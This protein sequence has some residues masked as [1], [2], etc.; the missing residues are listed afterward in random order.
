[1]FNWSAAQPYASWSQV[2]GNRRDQ[3]V[4]VGGVPTSFEWTDQ[5]VALAAKHRLTLLPE[6]VYAPGWD[7]APH[8]AGT[9]GI[10][11]SDAAYAAFLKALVQ[12]Y[13]AHGS[14]WGSHSPAVPIRSWQIWNEPNLSIF[15]P[16][17]PFARSYVALLSAAHAAIKSADPGARIVL[18]GMPNFSWTALRQVY[19]VRGA[20]RLF[21]E[22]AVHPYTRRPEGVIT[23]LR[24]VRQVMN[25]AGDRRKPLIADEISWPSSQGKT[26]VTEGFDFA[27]TEAGQAQNL[28]RL[29]PILGRDRRTLR[30]AGFDYYNWAGV[31]DPGADAFEYSGLLRF[32]GGRFLAK[33]AF[34]AFRR[35]A[36]ALEGRR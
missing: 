35:A 14:F 28:A 17:Q 36:L 29:L 24:K 9:Y 30:L 8:P 33:P 23:I 25:R 7:T 1:V 2:P 34:Y 12:R 3:F 4:D 11:A 21:D 6:V 13:G 32:S 22:V 19:A 10:P 20:R 5:L 27:T 31:E 16:V 18:A 15:W 26:S